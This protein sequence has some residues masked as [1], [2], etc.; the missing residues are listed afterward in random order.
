MADASKIFESPDF[1][2][3]LLRH[4]CHCPTVMQ[5]AK[6]SG[7]IAEDFFV[8]D[9]VGV[10]IYREFARIVLHIGEAPINSNLLMT[11]IKDALDQG[12]LSRD[13]IDHIGNLI[14]YLTDDK[15]A[16]NPEFVGKELINFIKYR[17]ILKAKITNKDD[18]DK[19]VTDYNQVTNDLAALEN[20]KII[21]SFSPFQDLVMKPDIKDVIP[22][23]LAPL[24]AIIG[25]Y[26]KG[27]Y[28][29]MVGF[30]G[31]GKTLL[32]T[33]MA[34]GAAMW[35]HK[36][37]IVEMEE[38][39]ENICNR[40]YSS[41]FRI[42]Y[43]DLYQNREGVREELV[44]AFN[45]MLP[46]DRRELLNIQVDDLRDIEPTAKRL[47][48]WLEQRAKDTGFFPDVVFLDQ[49]DFIY[50]NEKQHIN[51]AKWE[52]YDT[53]SQELAK[54]AQYKIMGRWG[55]ALCCLHQATGD[56]KMLFGRSK[57]GGYSGIIKPAALTMG[58]G[59]PEQGKPQ[60]KMSIFSEKA[61]HVPSFNLQF[62]VEPVFME[63]KGEHAIVNGVSLT[64][65]IPSSN[66]VAGPAL[67]AAPP[68]ISQSFVTQHLQPNVSN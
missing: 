25:G 18:I 49:M 52:R 55:F 63:I 5:R 51:K 64:R 15:G 11:F 23:G 68:V 6:D 7:L 4:L 35:G 2:E 44:E 59:A 66:P 19:L 38:M 9:S 21:R 42:P 22:T 34:R 17:R 27:E 61:R 60:D 33:K 47:E 8:E 1:L 48:Q 14:S 57:I 54:L 28:V 16:L 65:E 29:L 67:C 58:I 20:T 31:K 36:V 37:L 50:P 10:K 43:L 40:L 26:S 13:Q 41:R 3:E 24:D 32:M 46:E 45:Q 39:G 56:P 30:S 53:V 12:L 62:E